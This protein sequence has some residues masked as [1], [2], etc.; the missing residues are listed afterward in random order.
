MQISHD[1]SL[2]TRVF[3]AIDKSAF[4][5]NYKLLAEA[6]PPCSSACA[7]VKANSYGHGAA[8]LAKELERHTCRS[9]NAPQYFAVADV[10]EA[11]DLRNHGIKTPIIILGRTDPHSA[12]ILSRFFIT[13]CVHSAEYARELSSK[14]SEGLSVSCHIKLDTGMTRLGFDVS[15]DAAREKTVSEISAIHGI[16]NLNFT[17]IFSHF[18]VADEP[19]SGFSA[20]QITR[21][22]KT[23]A[24]LA[25][26]GIKF[27][28]RHL[29]NSA[30]TYMFNLPYELSRFGIMLYGYYPS[31]ETKAI[32]EKSHD[33]VRPVMSLCAK[34]S[35]IHTPSAGTT[36]GYG[37]T[38]VAKGGE[39]IACIAAGYADGVPR[40]LSNSGRAI[41]NNCRF[42]GNVCMD[43]CFIDVTDSKSEI[44]EGDTVTL[45]GTY[46]SSGEI[47]AE[48]WAKT[49]NTI[50]YE[51][52]C[53]ISA[54]VPR[55]YY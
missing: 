12:D 33:P 20:E 11:I 4:L 10:G 54:R 5:H 28:Y 26:K 50:S 19:G 35:Q 55:M 6:M 46:G 52:L 39:R 43:M 24:L 2:N 22:D 48:D 30:G 3:T 1:E 40:L 18:A 38:Y 31:E 47:S 37:R 51:I 8:V 9:E 21:F 14:L 15:D 42:V 25:E 49:A 13:Q 27:K 29:A 36:I 32:W 44:R 23:V 7:V 41:D 45:F 17:G 53:G 16:E 34:V